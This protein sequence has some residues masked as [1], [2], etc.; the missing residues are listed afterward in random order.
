MNI[1]NGVKEHIV[2]NSSKM[3]HQCNQSVQLLKTARELLEH[4]NLHACQVVIN[5]ERRL[6]GDH[7]RRFNVPI[8]DEIGILMPNEL[9]HNWDTVLQYRDGQLQH[10]TKLHRLDP[11][12]PSSILC[13]FLMEL[14]GATSTCGVVMG[15]RSLKWHITPSTSWSGIQTISSEHVA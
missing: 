5:E 3:L 8:S 2:N 13:C 14:M 12:M 4:D 1:T 7:A 15:R 6:P 9:T 10:V 11:M